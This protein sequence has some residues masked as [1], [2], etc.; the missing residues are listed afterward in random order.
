MVSESS[1]QDVSGPHV[2][3]YVQ[4][5][6]VFVVMLRLQREAWYMFLVYDLHNTS[7]A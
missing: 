1:L 6:E 5:F 2:G 4:N 7:N 3:N